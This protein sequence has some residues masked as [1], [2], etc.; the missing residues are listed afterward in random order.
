VLYQTASSRAVPVN[1]VNRRSIIEIDP[2]ASLEL[3]TGDPLSSASS[4]FALVTL[5]N[6]A[7]HLSFL[8]ASKEGLQALNDAGFTPPRTHTLVL[9]R[10]LSGLSTASSLRVQP[11]GQRAGEFDLGFSSYQRDLRQGEH[12]TLGLAASQLRFDLD[13]VQRSGGPSLPATPSPGS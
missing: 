10:A 8:D 12:L 7:V 4:E 3:T 1:V 2:A 9:T 13:A 5:R 6:H 11:A